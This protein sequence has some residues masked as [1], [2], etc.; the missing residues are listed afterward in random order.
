VQ[1]LIR[2]EIVVYG[3][4]QRV[5]YRY[6]VQDIARRL[7]VKGYVQNMP[8][9]TVKIIAEGPKETM[10]RFIKALKVKEPPIKIKRIQTKF[11]KPTAEFKYFTIKYGKLAD[12]IA[13]GF[14]TGLKYINLS[15][16]ETKQG[17]QALK[18]ET[19]KGFQTLQTE[20]KVGFQ[21]V[22]S[23]IKDM[24]NDMNQNFQETTAKY[25]VIS[26]TLGEAVKTIQEESI[27]TR[28]ELIRAVD[29]LSRLVEEFIKGK[30]T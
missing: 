21:T 7:N 1:K 20:T 22:V 6:V 14:G 19:K 30:R 5:G 10:K 28:K 18:T 27:K 9:G 11:L 2:A 23:E 17:F 25:D 29:N 15:R 4:V 26:K 12:E 24:R 16:S 13:G 3:E 8:D